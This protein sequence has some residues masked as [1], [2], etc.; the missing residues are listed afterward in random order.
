[1]H[2]ELSN[3]KSLGW[4]LVV[5]TTDFQEFSVYGRNFSQ[6][7][8]VVQG[9]GDLDIFLSRSP[10]TF[11]EERNLFSAGFVRQHIMLGS[12]TRP[13]PFDDPRGAGK[14]RFIAMIACL[15]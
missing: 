9:Q 15:L 13:V 5:L 14:T 3:K 6:L 1:M 7:T 10:L 12:G 11:G 2:L 4:G 8:E